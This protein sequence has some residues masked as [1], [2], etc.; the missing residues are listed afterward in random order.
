MHTFLLKY[1]DKITLGKIAEGFYI[2]H[3]YHLHT[4]GSYLNSNDRNSPPIS[5]WHLKSSIRLS[6]SFSSVIEVTCWTLYSLLLCVKRCGCGVP[7]I[8]K[9][10]RTSMSWARIFM[11]FAPC[12][13]S[14]FIICKFL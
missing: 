14:P 8:L 12:Y 11:G 2:F 10:A 1:I 4:F 6:A 5:L 9:W 7:L 3:K 13:Y